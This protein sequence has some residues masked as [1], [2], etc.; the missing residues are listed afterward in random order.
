[1]VR[2]ARGT[3]ARQAQGAG[4]SEPT[5]SARLRLVCRG[6]VQGVGF[7]PTVHRLASALRL[8]GFVRNDPEGVVIEVEG[9]PAQVQE[10]Q[11]ALPV[12]LPPLASLTDV[13]VC[14][15]APRGEAGFVVLASQSGLR[16]R[17]L[18]P[19]DA[20]LCAECR[21]EMA[22]PTDRRYRYPFTTCTNCG[23]RFTLVR[24]LPYDR[25]RTSMACFP[26][27]P[28]CDAEYRDPADRR[29]HAEPVCCPACGPR[30]WLLLDSPEKMLHSRTGD[31]AVATGSAA[32]QK[33]R[34]VLLAGLV[35]AVKGF[36]GFQLA[37][38]ADDETVVARLRD[39]KHRPSKPLA[40]MVRDLETARRFVVL[41]PADEALLA[42]PRAPVLLAPRRADAPLAPGVAPGLDDLGVMLPTTPLHVELFRSLELEALVMTSGNAADEPIC[43][44]NRE[45]L[46]RLAGIADG[47]LLHDRDVVRRADDS[48]VR[49]T[50][51]GPVLV[52][53]ARGYVPEALPLPLPAEVPVL[54][55]GPY[56]QATACLAV[57]HEAFF[58]QHVGDLDSEAARAFLRETVE[59]LEDFLAARGALVVVDAHPDYPSTWL[60][61]ELSQQR[62][63]PL[64]RVQHHLAH[65]AAT[66]AE[67]GRFPG[68][69]DDALA[70]ILD[71]TGWGPDGTAWGGEWLLIEGRRRWRRVAHLE[72]LPLVGGEA[73]V[74]APWR[75]LGAALVRAGAAEL[76]PRLPVAELVPASELASVARLAAHPGWPMASGAGRVFEAAGAMLGLAAVNGYEGEAAARLEA[77]A[78]SWSGPA[79]PWDEVH[80]TTDDCAASRSSPAGDHATAVLP[81]AALLAA[82]A[83]RAL[84][85]ESPASIAAGFH[86]T[87]CRLA[88]ELTRRLAPPRSG[89]IALGGGCF[90]NRLL[91]RGLG[92]TL[93]AIG[94]EPLLP[95]V[96]PPGDGGISYGQAVLGAFASSGVAM[97]QGGA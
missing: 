68:P 49:A 74:R 10:F 33:A 32:L 64:L 37:C 58:A 91:R 3:V 51:A 79:A 14:E 39:R 86:A 90:V 97:T 8:G 38:R 82:A 71:G 2:A 40:L 29:F 27:C 13:T 73:A 28:R 18:V 5:P 16:R 59:E 81:S 41:A 24:A 95:F 96:V 80:L 36:G 34:D 65:A 17:A 88:A 6:V 26:L 44:G 61:E 77:L 76:L 56:L 48:V 7:R 55:L 87:F 45:A 23:P 1:M 72:A 42:S 9:A 83:R 66:L 85:G 67:H 43:R 4:V 54:A 75:V 78:A 25:E 63:A 57:D 89:V 62:G 30:L 94:L 22:D 60:G 20:A 15:L 21:N 46:A 47:F 84:A 70:L 53:R 31:D 92:E 12:S 35:V 69:D 19:P 50:E 52:R 11:R 93:S